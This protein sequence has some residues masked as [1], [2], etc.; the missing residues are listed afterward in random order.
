MCV[1]V[2]EIT[3][4]QSTVVLLVRLVTRPPSLPPPGGRGGANAQ[5]DVGLSV[6]QFRPVRVMYV[7]RVV[8]F[9]K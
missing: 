5:T 4:Y 6:G 3:I 9:C 7:T 8:K 1:C 2:H